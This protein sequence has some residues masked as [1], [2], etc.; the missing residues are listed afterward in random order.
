MS[1][2]D[3][4]LILVFL[5][6]VLLLGG[7]VGWGIQCLHPARPHYTP[8]EPPEPAY[9]PS[10]RIDPPQIVVMPVMLPTSQVQYLPYPQRP[11]PHVIDMPAI[12]WSGR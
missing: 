3:G 4:V 10:E 11:L 1:M 9:L 2:L 5:A 6:P 8:Q 12:E 7:A